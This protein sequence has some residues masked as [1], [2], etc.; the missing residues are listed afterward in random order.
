MSNQAAWLVEGKGKPL[1][2]D[3]AELWKPGPDEVL[4]KVSAAA[5]N[6]IDWKM[7]DYG[8]FVQ[9]YPAIMGTVRTL[10]RTGRRACHSP[11]TNTLGR[12]DAHCIPALLPLQ[13]TMG[14]TRERRTSR[15]WSRT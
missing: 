4:I 5:V 14:L 13:L 7:Q 9:S 15:A 8:I 1:K 6:P 3:E 12:C 2:V 10:S 11:F